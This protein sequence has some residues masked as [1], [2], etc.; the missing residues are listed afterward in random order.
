MITCQAQVDIVEAMA[1]TAN[2]DAAGGRGAGSA[3]HESAPKQEQEQE[4]HQEEEGSGVAAITEEAEELVAEEEIQIVSH[5]LLYLNFHS[6]FAR[7][8]MRLT[9]EES[10]V[11]LPV[12]SLE[13][14]LTHP[15]HSLTH[16]ALTAHAG[17]ERLGAGQRLPLAYSLYSLA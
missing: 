15:V 12:H 3:E 1:S 9:V 11:Q 17:A 7:A 16:C 13:P 8:T 10:H 4:Q 14:A 5:Y 2:T 6:P